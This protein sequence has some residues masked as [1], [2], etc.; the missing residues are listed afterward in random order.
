M[1]IAPTGVLLPVFKGSVLQRGAPIPDSMGDN[2]N[3]S[4]P[5]DAKLKCIPSPDPRWIP[6]LIAGWGRGSG[7]HRTPD[8]VALLSD[9]PN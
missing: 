1:Y 2:R 9:A 8:T 3:H 6:K 5:A 4:Q 7:G